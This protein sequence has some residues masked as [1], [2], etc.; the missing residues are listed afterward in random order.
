[1]AAD[2]LGN[3]LEE[4]LGDEDAFADGF[5]LNISE[6]PRDVT[7]LIDL[8]DS[9]VDLADFINTDR[10]AVTGHSL[11][12]FTALAYPTRGQCRDNGN[13][14]GTSPEGKRPGPRGRR[15]WSSPIPRD[16][17]P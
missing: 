14:H 9:E 4:R 16:R 3:T 10:V 1:M 17:C 13:R 6:R 8:A 7:R 11:G 15:S 5:I 12:G 2:H